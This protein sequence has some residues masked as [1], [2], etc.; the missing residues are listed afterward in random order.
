MNIITFGVF[1]F[2]YILTTVNSTDI[3]YTCNVDNCKICSGPGFCGLCETNY[4]LAVN[5]TS[6]APYCS[7]VIC[8]INNCHHC[9][10]NNYCEHCANGYNVTSVGQCVANGGYDHTCPNNCISCYYSN[11]CSRCAYGY[12]L[13]AG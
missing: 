12:N 11:Q 1:V 5:F 8:N 10:E 2:S 6:G 7:Q 9:L 3:A 13:Q 4:I